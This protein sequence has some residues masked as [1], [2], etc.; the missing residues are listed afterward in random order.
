MSKFQHNQTM[1]VD[2]SIHTCNDQH[3]ASCA[4]RAPQGFELTAVIWP[5]RYGERPVRSPF[6]TFRSCRWY[7]SIHFG[8]ISVQASPIS[9]SLQP[10]CL[11]LSPFAIFRAFLATAFS[12]TKSVSFSSSLPLFAV[13]R[14]RFSEAFSVLPWPCLRLFVTCLASG[15][16]RSSS[17]SLG[18]A[19]LEVLQPSTCHLTT[20]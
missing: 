17:S 19:L 3:I 7:F 15:S 14:L 16:S 13:L 4:P 9:A 10:S 1:H 11:S 8:S 2:I 5:T 20:C 12:T 6:V 18:V